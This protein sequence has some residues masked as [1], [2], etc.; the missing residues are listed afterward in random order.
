MGVIVP[1]Y[2]AKVSNIRRTAQAG[3]TAAIDYT[4]TPRG[5]VNPREHSTFDGRVD[6]VAD[7]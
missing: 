6:R 5:G 4:Y 2:A 3:I 1:M 7:H